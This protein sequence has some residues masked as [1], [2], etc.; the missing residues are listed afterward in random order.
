MT[1]SPSTGTGQATIRTREITYRSAD[2]ATL[3]GYYACDEALAGPRPGVLVVHEWWGLNDYAKRRARELA[4]LGYST[5]AIDM[6]GE[7]RNTA[8]MEQ[9][10]ALMLEALASPAGMR[11]RFLAGFEQLRQQPQTDS[12]Q[13]AAIGYCFGGRVVLDMARQGVPL[14]GVVSFHGLLDT[15]TPA[16]PG[17]VQAKVLV[18][19][20]DADSLISADQIARFKDEMRAAGADCR[21]QHHSDAPHAFSNPASPGYQQAADE[22]SWADMQAFFAELFG[23]A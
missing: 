6:Y 12:A 1:T 9:A 17:S 23:R 15:V 5:L 8:S 3:V 22:N 11:E 7:G 18:A 20:G 10:R 13:L 14:A 2:G 4:A 21:F 19:H 16:T